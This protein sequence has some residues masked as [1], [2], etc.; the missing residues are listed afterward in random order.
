MSKVILGTPPSQMKGAQWYLRKGNIMTLD[1]LGKMPPAKSVSYLKVTYASR[2]GSKVEIQYWKT[3]SNGYMIYVDCA[4]MKI[5]VVLGL[6]ANRGIEASTKREF[7]KNFNSV[8][9]F[10]KQ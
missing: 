6:N 5:G 2:G 1:K 3:L 10:L 8:L 7:D 4:N 9:K